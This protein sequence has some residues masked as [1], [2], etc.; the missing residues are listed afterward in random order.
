MASRRTVQF[1]NSMEAG[2]TD[3][4]AVLKYASSGNTYT[5]QQWNQ[6]TFGSGT[7]YTTAPTG[8][9]GGVKSVSRTSTGLLVVTFGSGSTMNPTDSYR[10]LVDLYVT[11]LVATSGLPTVI[12][13]GATPGTNSTGLDSTG[14][15]CTVGL[16][17][18]TATA[19]DPADGDILIIHFVL[20]NSSASLV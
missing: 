6:G 16:A 1:R 10:R 17:S 13:A 9:Y 8:G 11:S 4:M 2:L 12:A 19:S 18:A 15:I 20:Q 3:I 14:S 7:K 5:L